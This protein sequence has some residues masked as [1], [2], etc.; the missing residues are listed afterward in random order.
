MPIPAHH[1]HIHQRPAQGSLFIKRYQAFNYQHTISAQG[2]FDT[3]SCDISVRGTAEG[4]DLISNMLGSYVKIVVDNPIVP[5]WEGLINRITYNAGGATYTISLDE[6]ANRVSVV[7]TGAANA[8]AE[9]TIVNNTVSQAIYGIKQDQIEF[10]ADPS[11]GSQRTVLGNTILAQRAFPQTAISQPMGQANTVH[12][13]LIGIFH[14]LEWVKFFTATSAA[15]TA[16]GTNVGVVIGADPNGMTF[17]DNTDLTQ[18]SA[19]AA[20]VKSQERASSY[21][22]R[23]Q[24]IAEAGDGTNYWIVGIT[25]THPNTHTRVAYYRVFN[26]A[27]EYVAFQSDNLKPRNAFGKPI[28]P[29]L[30]VPNRVIRVNDLLVGFTNPGTFD[31]RQ[32]WISSIQYDMNSQSVQWI[33]T[34]DTTAKG[35]FHMRRAFKPI[36]KNMPG[37]APTRVIVT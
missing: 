35:A 22:E 15:S 25:P 37:T 14:T 36:A 8:A 2:W 16:F 11:A 30:V 3:A 5:I 23:L 4:Q 31:P 26:T 10:G 12:I 6:M 33:G 29:W 9:T 1:I 32:T 17:Y 18:I 34:D 27:V 24:K 28:A 19:N 21:W 13:E 20:T 7:Y